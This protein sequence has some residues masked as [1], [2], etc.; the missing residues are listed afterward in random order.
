VNGEIHVRLAGGP[1]DGQTLIW[2]GSSM[3]EFE[4]KQ[5]I[6]FRER[7]SSAPAPVHSV[8]RHRYVEAGRDVGGYFVFRF[9]GTIG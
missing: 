6:S 7:P 2:G 9:A 3:I 8:R 1:L 4:D 5:P